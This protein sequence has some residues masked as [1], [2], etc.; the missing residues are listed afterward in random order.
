MLSQRD[1]PIIAVATPPGRGAI[2]VIR[3]SGKNLKTFSAQLLKQ[4]LRP[5]SVQLVIIKDDSGLQI[6]QVLAIYFPAPQSYTGE[7]I[8]ELQGHGGSVVLQMLLKHCLNVAQKTN[9]YNQAFLPHLRLAHPGEF[10]ERAYLNQKL[11]LIQAEAVAD[12]IDANTEAAVRSAGRSLQGEFSRKTF[13]LKDKLVYLRMQIEACLDFPEEDIDFIEKIQVNSQLNAIQESVGNLLMEAEKGRLLR[14]GIKL[15]IAGQP[16]VGKSSLM[17]ALSGAEVAIVTAI[18]GTTRDVLIQNI[19]IEGVPIYLLDTAGLRTKEIA[20]EVEQIGILRAWQHIG[21]ADMILVLNDLS[22]HGE[23]NYVN[24][25]NEL[26]IEIQNQ[27]NEKTPLIIINN[28][29]D[30]INEELKSSMVELNISAK[31]GEGLEQL[32]KLILTKAGWLTGSNEGIVTA[33]TRHI[34]ALQLVKKHINEAQLCTA[35]Q[36]IPI[37]LMAE[38]CRLALNELSKLTGDFNSDDLLGEIFSRFCI[39]K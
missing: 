6:D 25:Q 17:N 18:A 38:E 21:E 34:N 22:R 31:T 4:P 30:V 9:Q 3:L 35:K 29:T 13:V 16:N 8:L 15:V 32:K 10:T 14:D 37:D 2:G 23:T 26:I 12:L 39:G 33:R 19:Q 28:K 20:D 36:H 24:A 1:D 11:D 5:R 27:K 7:D